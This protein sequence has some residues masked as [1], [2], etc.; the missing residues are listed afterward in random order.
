MNVN[1]ALSTLPRLPKTVTFNE[2]QPHLECEVALEVNRY[3][4]PI[5]SGLS[6]FGM[7][8]RPSKTHPVV[9]NVLFVNASF[10]EAI[11]FDMAPSPPFAFNASVD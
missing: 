7:A 8:A 2:R 9:V 4:L 10:A 5:P 6:L 3:E 1:S 11:W